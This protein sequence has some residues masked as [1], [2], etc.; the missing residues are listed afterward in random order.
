MDISMKSEILEVT[1]IV[2]KTKAKMFK[3]LVVG[4]KIQLSIPVKYAGSNRGT[5]ASYI[6]IRNLDN[7][8]CAFKSFNEITNML[9]NFE[10]RVA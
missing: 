8:E 1:K 4:S 5:Y 3:D 10:F 2:K 9:N 7:D 6:T